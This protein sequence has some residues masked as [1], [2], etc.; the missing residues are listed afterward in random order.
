MKILVIGYKNHARKI[1]DHCVSLP[2]VEEVEVYHP[3]PHRTGLNDLSKEHK[4]SII[5]S[6][7]DRIVDAIFIAS[8]PSTH[9][10]YIKKIIE[11][12]SNKVFP[13]I[14]C[15]KPCGT[16]K[17]ELGYLASL[18]PEFKSRIF[19]GFNYRHSSFKGSF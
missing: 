13:Y 9:V 4:I 7:Y 6:L 11:A 14:Y 2:F 12:S 3:N 17:T 8:P 5:N 10:E 16:T 19:F 1:I 15:E 18:S